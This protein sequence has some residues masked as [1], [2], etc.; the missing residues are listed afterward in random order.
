MR[1]AEKLR[2]GDTWISFLG[3]AMDLVPCAC[4]DRP[5]IEMIFIVLLICRI[6]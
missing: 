1:R 4:Q 3:L 2:C 5:S 6:L